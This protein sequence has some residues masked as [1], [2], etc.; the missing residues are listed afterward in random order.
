MKTMGQVVIMLRRIQSRI[1]WPYEATLKYDE[2][3]NLLEKFDSQYNISFFR[4][5]WV[6]SLAVVEAIRT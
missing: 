1:V 6:E 4:N 3:I 5:K 2:V